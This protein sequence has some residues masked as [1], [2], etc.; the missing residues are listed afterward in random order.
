MLAVSWTAIL[1]SSCIAVIFWRTF[2]PGEPEW[3]PWLHFIGLALLFALTCI[4]TSLKPL[5]SFLFVLLVIFGLGYGGGWKWGLIQFIIT[6]PVGNFLKTQTPLS[7]GLHL[8]RLLPAAVILTF[9]LMKGRKRA[10]FFLIKGDVRALVVPSKL[11]G[12]KKAEPWTRI[13]SIFSVIFTSG[14]F[15]FLLLRSNKGSIADSMDLFVTVPVAV[16]IAGINAFN[17]EFTLRAAPLSEIWQVLGKQQALLI[18]T[19]YFGIGHYYGVPNGVIG[20]FLS[21]F[22]G[23]FL[24]KSLMETKG[25]FWAWFIHVLQ[26]IVIFTFYAVFPA[27]P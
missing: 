9:F 18:T 21:A 24:G 12:M 13:G 5:R 22:L 16:L 6:S 1:L 3:W 11:L 17:E 15:I 20:V 8:L 25:F 7:I 2:T 14:G 19:I 23:W 27:M 10:E 4:R 26:D